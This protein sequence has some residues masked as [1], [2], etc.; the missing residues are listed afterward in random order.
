[1][2]TLDARGVAGRYDGL[3]LDAFGVLVDSDGAIS[4]APEFVG[5]LDESEIPYCVITN[6]ASRQPEAVSAKLARAGM[7]IPPER[8]LTSGQL[9]SS[10]FET[11]GLVGSRCVVLGPDDSKSYVRQAGGRVLEP[12]EALESTFEALIIGDESGYPFLTSIDQVLGPL[13]AAF[14][15]GRPPQLIVPNPDLVY[16]KPNSGLGLASGGVAAIFEAVLSA[17]FPGHPR[18]RFTRL[19]KPAP[20]LFEAARR[21]LG[22]EHVVMFGDTPATDIAGAHAAGIDAALILTGVT[23]RAPATP[24]HPTYVLPDLR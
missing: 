2:T 20:D 9:L 5:W 4:G 18:A 21:R 8:V 1:M 23:K 19:G 13:V 14:D 3:L 22:A 16:P 6:D 12:A 11:H 15:A 7:S 17:K 24:P 10:H